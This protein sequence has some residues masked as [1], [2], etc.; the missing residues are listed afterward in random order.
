M[1]DKT[2]F[3]R[4]YTI[5][6]KNVLTVMQ[7]NITQNYIICSKNVFLKHFKF[8]FLSRYKN[9][10]TKFYDVFCLT[11]KKMAHKYFVHPTK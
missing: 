1:F 2:L 9:F 4:V 3:R 7:K 11:F 6:I 5:F 8:I 10:K